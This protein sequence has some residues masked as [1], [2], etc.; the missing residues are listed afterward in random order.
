MDTSSLP[1]AVALRTASA[2]CATCSFGDRGSLGGDVVAPSQR[3]TP[4]PLE[5]M[6]RR[7][8]LDTRALR[9]LEG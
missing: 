7:E 3:T 1:S 8:V 6:Q 4:G 2:A 5:L 9:T